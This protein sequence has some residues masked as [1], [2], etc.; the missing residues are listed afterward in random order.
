MGHT[1]VTG[2]F[3][4]QIVTGYFSHRYP[5]LSPPFREGCGDIEEKR[6]QQILLEIIVTEEGGLIGMDICYTFLNYSHRELW[7]HTNGINRGII[8]RAIQ[9]T[10]RDGYRKEGT[11]GQT[12]ERLLKFL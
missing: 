10:F 5:P 12:A 7:S 9:K 11:S 2:Y 3:S 1:I 8:F 6:G 4:H